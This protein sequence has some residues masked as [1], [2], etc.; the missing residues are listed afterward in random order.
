MLV[1]LFM[2]TRKKILIA[3][4]TY[5]PIFILWGIFIGTDT[6]RL[7]ELP[8]VWVIA[9]ALLFL[10]LPLVILLLIPTTND[11]EVKPNI[12]QTKRQKVILAVLLLVWMVILF[13]CF[14]E[15]RT[16]FYPFLIIQLPLLGFLIYNLVRTK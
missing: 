13:V 16:F 10:L 3:L 11:K 5:C 15:N 6:I 2:C 12:K 1:V 7:S 14:L 4:A 9:M 8:L